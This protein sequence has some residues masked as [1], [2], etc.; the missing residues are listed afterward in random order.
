MPQNYRF[1]L[2]NATQGRCGRQVSLDTLAIRDL[3]LL[4]SNNRQSG[5][6]PAKKALHP[7]KRQY[8]R[9]RSPDRAAQKTVA[10]FQLTIPSDRR[11]NTVMIW[12]NEQCAVGSG[13]VT[14]RNRFAEVPG[15]RSV[16][17]QLLLE[18]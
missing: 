14:S 11:L 9:N 15:E 17:R 4:E 5:L 7:D 1:S 6:Y 18:Q 16:I 10:Q 2:H 8:D 3:K 13:R 12:N